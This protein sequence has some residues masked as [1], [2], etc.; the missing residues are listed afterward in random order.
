MIESSTSKDRRAQLAGTVGFLFQASFSILLLIVAKVYESD[1]AMAVAVWMLG[2]VV[3]WPVIALVYAQRRRTAQERLE[4]EELKR[5]H[6]ADGTSGIFDT[7][8]EAYLIEKRRLS[9]ILRWVVPFAALALAGYHVLAFFFAFSWE[10]G[11]QLDADSWK[12]SR[13]AGRIMAFVGGVGFLSFLFSRYTAGM[14]RMPGWR[15]LRSGA[16]FL[17]GNAIAC[18]ITVIAIG[19]QGTDLPNPEAIAAYVIRIAMFVV[20]IEF[21]LNFVLDFYRPREAGRESRPAFDSRALALITEPGGIARSIAD[22]INYQFG[23]E[24]SS[25]W[26]YQLLKRAALPMLAFGMLTLFALSCVLIVDADEEV[27]LERFGKRLNHTGNALTPGLYLKAPWPIDIAY[28]SRVKQTR[29]LTIGNTPKEA[30]QWET[31]EG[32]KRLKPVVWG[33]KHD[34]SSE[35]LLVVASPEL[36]NLSLAETSEMEDQSIK[37]DAKAVAVGL[38]MISV[39]VQY[40]VRDIH[41]YIYEYTDPERLVEATAYQVLT[42]YAASVD[43]DKFLGPGQTEINEALRKILQQQMDSQNL[44]VEILYVGLQESHP[45]PDVAKSF[46]DVVKAEREK[47]AL[48]EQARSAAEV[49]LTA[50]AGSRHRALL[51]DQ[52]IVKRDLIA[53]DPNIG[54]EELVVADQRVNELLLGNADDTIPPTGGE[55]AARLAEVQAEVQADLT[56]ARRS[57]T[58]FNAEVVAYSAAPSLYKIRKY[59]DVLKRSLVDV[60]K[61]IVVADPNKRIIIEYEKEEKGTIELA[62]PQK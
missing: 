11:V 52:A 4:S 38:L 53:Q 5:A 44:G 28:R 47:D 16:S 10:F 3:I 19:L 46:Q 29:M 60:R 51:L 22:A 42:D 20:G 21:V 9:W 33:K 1:A 18:L 6:L 54:N 17:A 34:F 41:S 59:L 27:V 36:T 61:Y 35:M 12:L 15:M 26:F 8:D 30:E 37:R 56:K 31:F 24:V 49:L 57:L 40:R 58:L 7:E 45:T 25:T 62:E 50:M 13:E 55:A 48:I 2:G 14:A 32:R 43:V 23:F 39:E